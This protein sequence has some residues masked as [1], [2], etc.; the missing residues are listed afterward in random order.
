[1]LVVTFEFSKSDDLTASFFKMASALDTQAL[2][3]A[4]RAAQAA[5]AGLRERDD[6]NVQGSAPQGKKQQG[7]LAFFSKPKPAKSSKTSPPAVKASQQSAP[8]LKPE[9]AKKQP[10]GAPSKPLATFFKR[11]DNSAADPGSPTLLRPEKSDLRV[12]CWPRGLGTV[13]R[14]T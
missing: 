14:G 2:D 5:V 11:S 7:I 8:A 6:P 1:M 12:L 10:A 13:V 4:K 9:S 3:I